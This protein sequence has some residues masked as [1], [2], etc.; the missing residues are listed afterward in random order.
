MNYTIKFLWLVSFVSA[1]YFVTCLVSAISAF[2][3]R[4]LDS[5]LDAEMLTA[6]SIVR[7]PAALP[8]E[9]HIG[10]LDD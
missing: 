2:K 6:D 7:V 3:K 8:N 4:R 10:T 5:A 1:L 9:H